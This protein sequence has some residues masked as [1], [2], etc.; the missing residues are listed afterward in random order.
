MPELVLA[1]WSSISPFPVT[2]TKSLMLRASQIKEMFIS[3]TVLK[4]QRD[5]VWE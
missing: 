2:R 4:F 3:L 1:L 5:G